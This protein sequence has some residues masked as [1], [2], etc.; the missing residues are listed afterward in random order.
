MTEPSSNPFAVKTPESTSAEDVVSLFVDV[1]SDFQ[2][3]PHPGH[4]FVHGPRGSGKTM[5]FRFLEPDCQLLHKGGPLRGLPF[6]GVYVPIKNTDLSLT[7]FL[8]LRGSHAAP[9]LGEHFMSIHVVAKMLRSLEKAIA[10]D[11]ELGAQLAKLYTESFCPLVR[12]AESG[13]TELVELDADASGTAALAA[14]EDVING[15]HVDV[16]QYLRRLSFQKEAVEYS[17]AL[18]G[19][20]DFVVPLIRE[21]RKLPAFSSGPVFL[22]LDDADNLSETQTRI[23]N[24]W[25]S[26]RTTADISLK[27]ATQLAYKTFRT[28]AGHRVSAPHDFSEV[29]ISGVY[30]SRSSKYRERMRQIVSKRLRGCEP[31]TF[32]PP[33]IDQEER[34]AQIGAEYR[35]R[36]SDETRG[37]HARDDANRYARPDYIRD[38]SRHRGGRTNYSYAGFDQ[39]V[40]ISSG[41]VRHFLDAASSMY[42]EEASKAA[43]APEEISPATQ[44]SVVRQKANEFFYSQFEKIIQDEAE[45]DEERGSFGRLRNLI[46]AL[47]NAFHEILISD[48]SE[49]RVF[50]VALSDGGT[51]DVLEVLRLGVRYGYFHESTI[52]AKV[53][54][55]RVPLFILTRRLAPFFTLD[56]TSF[57]GYL[58]ATS[59]AL[60]LAMEHPTQ[61]IRKIKAKPGMAV[62]DDPQVP[63]PLG[64]P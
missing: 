5:M 22:L 26:T 44:D 35:G 39:L 17:G 57:A 16:V 8:R 30:T 63:L 42:D 37:Y 32:F 13:K 25:V 18:T 20:L 11:T 38:L 27:I 51:S 43:E 36:S 14:M 21:L 2:H 31:E 45:S 56:P 46:Q 40:H 29:S 48:A 3:V 9:V 10:L 15:M 53:G 62:L 47:G 12:N 1:F 4:T 50:S 58:F 54:I 52:G 49:R 24:S 55:G 41:V 7:D 33:N 59:A 60:R 61:F 34:I 28:T 19:Y 6:F 64:E 23:L